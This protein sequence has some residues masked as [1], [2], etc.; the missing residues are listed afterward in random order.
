VEYERVVNVEVH[1]RVVNG[2]DHERVY[3]R[4]PMSGCTMLGMCGRT[5]LGMCGRTMLG[6]YHAGY[7]PLWVCTT[8]PPWYI[9]HLPTLGIH[10][11]HMHRLSVAPKSVS[12][13]V[14]DNN[15]LGSRRKKNLG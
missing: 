14:R 2:E 6:M 8:Y 3:I 15:A 11:P 7:V 10:Q 5:M 9:P 1:E 4:W 12:G 13:T